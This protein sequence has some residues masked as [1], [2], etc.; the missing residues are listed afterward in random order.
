MEI[1]LVIAEGV[2]DHG[3]W[4]ATAQRSD[5][6]RFVREWVPDGDNRHRWR[7]DEV[8]LGR[9]PEEDVDPNSDSRL[10]RYG[11]HPVRRRSVS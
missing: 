3:V 8:R 1:W 6:E 11:V 2:Y 4:Y 9:E 10:T 5:A 7:I